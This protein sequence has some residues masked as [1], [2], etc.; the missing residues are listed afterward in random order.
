MKITTIETVILIKGRSELFNLQRYW[1]QWSMLKSIRCVTWMQEE[2]KERMGHK[3]GKNNLWLETF[4]NVRSKSIH[5][6]SLINS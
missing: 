2:E 6:R 1:G 5:L 3:K 4:Q